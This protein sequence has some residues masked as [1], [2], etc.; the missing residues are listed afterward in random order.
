MGFCEKVKVDR[1]ICDEIFYIQDLEED[2]PI[3]E[4]V[5]PPGSTIE[6][7][8]TV[9]V[10][11]CDPIVDLDEDTLSALLTFM[12]QKEL[13]IL[14]PDADEIPLE[15]GFR[16]EE[17]VEFRKCFPNELL[18]IDPDLLEDLECQIIFVSGTDEVELTPSTF[19]QEANAFL[20]DATFTE[21]LV[22]QIK[23]KLVQERQLVLALCPPRH[24]DEITVTEV[25]EDIA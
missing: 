20:K 6:G 8:V 15:F 21:D 12:I 24:Q 11:E 7:T 22:I 18:A 9:T 23:I 4:I 14:T 13:T 10:L 1:V 16:L 17:V 25:P 2:V 5:V 19:D 3:G